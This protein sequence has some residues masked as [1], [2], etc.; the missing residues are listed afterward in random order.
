MKIIYS[1][2]V[3]LFLASTSG[4]SQEKGLI[5]GIGGLA[6][7]T[8]SAISSTG[9]SKLGVGITVGGDY[10]VTD[11]ISVAPSFT[12]FFKSSYT[13]TGIDLSLNTSALDIDGKY[14][15][16][17]EDAKVYGLVGLTVGFATAT[18]TIDIGFGPTTVSA[19]DNEVGLNFGGGVDYYTSETMFLNGQIKYNT[20]LEQLAINL[21]VGFNF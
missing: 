8:K 3:L 12:Y 1:I 16:L 6:L 9:D 15:F 19:S 13:E 17:V 2:I 18:S 11:K 7:G 20:P 21:G 4:Y 14:Y 5:R 10:F